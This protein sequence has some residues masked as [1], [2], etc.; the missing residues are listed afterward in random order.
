VKSRKSGKRF[1]GCSNYSTGCRASAPLPQR[2]ALRVSAPCRRCSWPVVYVK[3]GRFP[4]KLCVNP[5]CPSKREK[6]REVRAV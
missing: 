3:T 6:K 5:N 4:W 1:V 2:G